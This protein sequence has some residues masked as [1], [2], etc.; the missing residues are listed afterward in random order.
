M[1]AI[2]NYTGVVEYFERLGINITTPS[3]AT[4]TSYYADFTTG[5]TIDYV[6]P[7]TTTEFAA[8]GAYYNV[9]SSYADLFVPSYANWPAPEDIPEDLLMPFGEFAVKYDLNATMLLMWTGI[10]AGLADMVNAPTLYVMQTFGPDTA[11]AFLGLN[12]QYIPSSGRNQDIYDAVASILGDSVMLNS[13]AVATNRLADDQGVSVVVQNTI[14]DN[15]TI[16]SAKRLI[17]SLEPTAENLAVFD[18]DATEAAVFDDSSLR[19]S[20]VQTGIITHPSLPVDGMIYNLPVAAASGDDFAFPEPPFVDYI[21]VSLAS[22]TRSPG[23]E[24]G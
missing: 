4:T 9:S 11:G 8:M 3:F 20:V 15:Y 14:T 7:D 12:G 22:P 5:E 24:T 13:V 16:V 21:Q 17:I 6:A 2:T 18:L 1:A 10:A 23:H 19:W